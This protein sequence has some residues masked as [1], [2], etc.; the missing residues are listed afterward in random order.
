MMSQLENG[1]HLF[2]A[3]TFK[4]PFE[5]ILEKIPFE[6]FTGDF[7]D[8]HDILLGLITYLA[9]NAK[10]LIDE[11]IKESLCRLVAQENLLQSRPKIKATFLHKACLHPDD[12]SAIRL[13]LLSGANPNAD[14]V[15]G[16]GP[17]HFLANQYRRFLAINPEVVGSAARILLEYG[18]HLCKVNDDAE[19]AADVWRKGENGDLNDLPDWLREEEVKN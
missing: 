9:R 19:T 7:A 11:D 5:F 13:L 4:K 3:D 8:D 2:I 14:D 15:Y 18:A 1:H 12:L 16:N 17:I 10:F 6:C